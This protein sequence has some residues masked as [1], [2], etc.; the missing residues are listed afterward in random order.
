MCACVVCI[1]LGSEI[2][3]WRTSRCL[4]TFSRCFMFLICLIFFEVDD[5]DDDD[6]DDDDD[7]D[8]TWFAQRLIGSTSKKMFFKGAS[9][10][11]SSGIPHGVCFA[12]LTS[13][14]W[15]VEEDWCASQNANNIKVRYFLSKRIKRC[16]VGALQFEECKKNL[17]G[18]DLISV[19]HQLV[20]FVWLTNIWV[21]SCQVK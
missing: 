20:F 7:D 9:L 12:P 14:T 13:C 19:F 1:S 11:A 2:S 21:T 18:Y 4:W 10:Q 8:A 17:K 5:D 6:G 16:T 15:H 3:Y